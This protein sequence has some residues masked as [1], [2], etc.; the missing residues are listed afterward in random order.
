M[1]KFVTIFVH[2]KSYAWWGA[3]RIARAHGTVEEHLQPELADG[4]TIRT[5]VPLGGMN[6]FF[7]AS[8]WFGVVLEKHDSAPDSSASGDSA[9]SAR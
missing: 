6:K 9:R 8:G 7:V 4:W 1:Q 2:S 5:I 3:S